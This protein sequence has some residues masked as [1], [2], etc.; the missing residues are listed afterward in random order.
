MAKRSGPAKR[1][2]K[3]TA[4]AKAKVAAK[5][6]AKTKPKGK[7]KAKGTAGA[8]ATSRP[9]AAARRSKPA[10][11]PKRPRPAKPVT[12]MDQMDFMRMDGMNVPS[13]EQ[14]AEAVATAAR[15]PLQ[16]RVEKE[17]LDAY[18]LFY[19]S[20]G[21]PEPPAKILATDPN[22]FDVDPGP[23]YEYL[24]ERFGVSQDPAQSYFG[25]F[26]GTI[27]D[28]IAFITPRWDGTLH[29]VLGAD[30]ALDD[31]DDD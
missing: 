9:S 17:M 20:P 28:A 12:E 26:G 10:T 8:S 23:F 13:R 7:A 27:A 31:D 4:K 3:T 15:N 14:R 29:T 5:A 22:D 1:P 2:A 25:G 30:G 16:V 11:K 24:E 21:K 6:N 18:R 19:P